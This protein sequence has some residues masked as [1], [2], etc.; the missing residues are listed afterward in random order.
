[1]S[2]KEDIS[3]IS[4][5]N[6]QYL[7]QPACHKIKPLF[8][9]IN[10]IQ[11]FFSCGTP[12]SSSTKS[13]TALWLRERHRTL[14]L[15]V[16]FKNCYPTR[17][18]SLSCEWC[19]CKLRSASFFTSLFFILE[20]HPCMM[21]KW[22]FPVIYNYLMS[23]PFSDSKCDSKSVRFHVFVIY[24]ISF[25]RGAGGGGHDFNS[26]WYLHCFVY[27]WFTDLWH[28]I[29][30]QSLQICCPVLARSTKMDTRCYL[31]SSLF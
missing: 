25:I 12:Y 21:A 18:F 27:L 11:N 29:R 7:G 19:W 3:Q 31:L 8:H 23:Y 13:V 1:M 15:K 2:V 6:F 5:S 22:H 20:E 26:A 28:H 30:V 17:I 16:G 10:K 24:G 4:V 14:D 9:F